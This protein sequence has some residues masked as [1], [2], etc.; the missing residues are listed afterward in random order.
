MCN[1]IFLFEKVLTESFEWRNC[2]MEGIACGDEVTVSKIEEKHIFFFHDI[3]YSLL[4]F[5]LCDIRWPDNFGVMA[6]NNSTPIVRW[7]VKKFYKSLVLF[8]YVE[9]KFEKSLSVYA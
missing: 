7:M 1:F 8:I 3:A 6:H 5:V 9:K 4:F 2:G